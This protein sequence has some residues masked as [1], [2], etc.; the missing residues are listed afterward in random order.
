MSVGLTIVDLDSYTFEVSC[1]TVVRSRRGRSFT[2]YIPRVI[3]S[4]TLEGDPQRFSGGDENEIDALVLFRSYSCNGPFLPA[5]NTASDNLL[6]E[7]KMQ[8]DSRT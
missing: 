7:E 3:Y 8:H 6:L 2:R 5:E 4:D 1:S